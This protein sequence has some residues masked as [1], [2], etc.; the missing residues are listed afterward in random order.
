MDM[1]STKRFEHIC[2]RSNLDLK[3]FGEQFQKVLAIP[4]MEYDFENETEWLTVDVNGFNYNISRPYEEGTLQ[5][6]DDTTPNDCNFGI[7]FS[8]HKD[9][10]YVLDNIW[11]DNMVADMCQQLARTFNTTVY[12]HRSF[13][14]DKYISEHKNIAFSP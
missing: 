6:W 7:V 3:S 1:K 8:I 14:F 9:H 13:T 5:Q 10:P 12:H 11:V 2:L 4:K